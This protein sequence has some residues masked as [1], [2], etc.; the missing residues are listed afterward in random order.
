MK[1]LVTQPP[2]PNVGAEARTKGDTRF[3]AS[4]L[5][6]CDEPVRRYFT[7]AIAHGASLEPR[8]RLR[9]KGRIKVA[10]WLP[11]TADQDCDGS[12]FVWRAEVPRHV[13]FLRVTDSY[14]DGRG[15]I[16]GRLLGAL[17]IFHSD[18]QNTVRSA[19]ARAATEGILAPIGLL[20]TSTR[21]WHAESDT[22]IVVDLALAPER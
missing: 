18:D 19:A 16:D 22:E 1:A 14:D 11:F 8:M 13:P 21:I 2:D 3:D 20:P 7:H 6:S 5:S 4:A 12:S 10:L 9:M 15:K 17:R